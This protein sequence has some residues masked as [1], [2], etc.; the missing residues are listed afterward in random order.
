MYSV[1][2]H[3]INEKHS[4]YGD[5][6][7]LCFLSKNL[8]NKANYIVRQEFI[9]TSKEKEEGLVNHATWIRYHEL[10]KQLIADENYM[11][12][13]RKVSNHILMQLDRNWASFFASIR[14]W[15]KYSCKYTDRPKL[16]KYKHKSKGRFGLDY[17]LGAIY[18]RNLKKGMLRLSGTD[19]SVP[20]K[21][22]DSKLIGARVSVLNGSYKIEIIYEKKEAKQ[23]E[24]NSKY[25]GVDPGV[26]NLMALT[27]NEKSFEP[28]IVN[29]RPVKAIN[30]YYNKMLSKYQSE[31]PSGVHT[32]RR[33]KRLANKRHNKMEHYFHHASNYI[34]KTCIDKQINTIVIGHNKGQK[35]EINIGKENNQKFVFI[36]FDSL[37][38][39][40]EYKAKLHGISFI[41][42]EESYT[43]KAS[44]LNLD[45][46]PV[47]N[48]ES[49]TKQ[50]FSGYR[51]N[52]GLY[53]I[54]GQKIYIN[55]DI[56][57]SYNIIRKVFPNAFADGIRE[58]AV[59]PAKVTFC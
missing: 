39:K 22:G 26:N 23:K 17:E 28:V 16:P 41:I 2:K 34:I 58:F 52:R 13:P 24:D 15:K 35:Q 25:M 47:Y 44:F 43:S 7:N 19:V 11:A 49:E 46:I 45:E 38:R 3:I 53:K 6:D 32:S 57:G 10:R 20:F 48:E 36:P 40:I 1:E 8:Y 18:K 42:N 59:I 29:G 21:N 12:L 9:K 33:I 31:L 4:L 51:K 30:Q 27:S 55:A 50:M 54:K 37:F 5:I 56:N 14:D